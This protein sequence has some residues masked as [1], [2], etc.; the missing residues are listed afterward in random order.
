LTRYSFFWQASRI[1]LSRFSLSKIRCVQ[2]VYDNVLGY[3]HKGSKFSAFQPA[4]IGTDEDTVDTC[5]GNLTLA[6]KQKICFLCIRTL[7]MTCRDVKVAFR[8]FTHMYGDGF[9]KENKRQ[10]WKCEALLLCF[11]TSLW[12]SRICAL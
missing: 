1:R 3:E 5:K 11:Q 10:I 6:G 7:M 4:S 8:N 2:Q 9:L 12:L